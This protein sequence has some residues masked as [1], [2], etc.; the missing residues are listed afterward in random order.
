MKKR[1]PFILN[2]QDAKKIIQ[3]ACCDWKKTLIDK[4]LA[5]QKKLNEFIE[6]KRNNR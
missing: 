3:I 5:S 2:I 1:F 4:W 6:K